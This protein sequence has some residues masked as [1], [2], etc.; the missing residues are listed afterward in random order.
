MAYGAPNELE[1]IGG[2]QGQQPSSAKSAMGGAASGAAAGMA[3]GPWGAVAGGALGLIGGLV[4]NSSAR[5]EA[6]R[7][8][9]AQKEMSDTAHQREIIDLQKAGLNPIL[10]GTGG[11]GSSSPMGPSAAQSD[12]VSSAVATY[13]AGKRQH[14]E[15]QNMRASRLLTG[16]QHNE[17]Y[18]HEKQSKAQAEKIKA[19]EKLT[20]QTLRAAQLEYKI[21]NAQSAAE[22]NQAKIDADA[23]GRFKQRSGQIAD[24]VGQW[25][26]AITGF[27][28]KGL[29]GSGKPAPREPK[30]FRSGRHPGAKTNH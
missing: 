10:S 13:Q 27:S 24:T 25:S 1:I 20:D 2:Q 26:K 30:V 7:A 29:F 22:I 9:L 15:L 5:K 16:Q 28:A 11:A 17:S 21:R 3:L 19:E 8:R 6:A 18:A 14:E 23:M 12:P 4:G